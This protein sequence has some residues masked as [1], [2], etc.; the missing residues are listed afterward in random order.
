MERKLTYDQWEAAHEKRE[1]KK[2]ELCKRILLHKGLGVVL[3]IATALVV[4]FVPTDLLSGGEIGLI[5]LAFV[6]MFSLPYD[7]EMKRRQRKER[8]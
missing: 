3:L 8:R 5:F 2:R 4:M 6:Y 1:A 7:L